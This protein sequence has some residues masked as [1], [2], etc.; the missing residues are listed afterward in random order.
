VFNVHV[1]AFIHAIWPA[2]RDPRLTVRE[3]AVRAL[4]ECLVVIEKRETR[5]G[6]NFTPL[7]RSFTPCSYRTG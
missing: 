5:W 7:S 3:A 4:R 2:L 1:P 6:C